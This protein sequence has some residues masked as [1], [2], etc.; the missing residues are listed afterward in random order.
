VFLLFLVC[1]SFAIAQTEPADK[2]D[3]A[4]AAKIDAYIKTYVRGNNFSGN[5]LL[6]RGDRIILRNSYGM[7]NFESSSR[8]APQT[9]FHIASLTKAFTAAAILIL[10]QRGRLNTNDAI[11]KYLPDYPGGEQITIHNL[12]THTSGIPDTYAIPEFKQEFE[13]SRVAGKLEGLAHLIQSHSSAAKPK[14]EFSYSNS[15]YILLAYIIEKL[16]GQT[17]GAFLKENI[18]EPLHLGGTLDDVSDGFNGECA[19]GYEPVDFNGVK[20][21]PYVNWSA[22][23]GAGSMIST[24]SDM[25][26]WV[27]GLYSARVLNRHSTDKMFTAYIHNMGYG[28]F[29]RSRLNRKSVEINGRISGFSSDLVYFPDEDLTIVVLAN[30]VSSLSGSLTDSIAAMTFG[31]NV[32]TVQVISAKAPR[33]ALED[34]PGTYQFG[35]NFRYN[36]DLRAVVQ[37]DGDRLKM[38]VGASTPTYLFP[39]ADGSFVDR[40]FSGVV[41][42]ERDASGKVSRLTWDVGEEFTAQKIPDTSK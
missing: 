22:T 37:R 7:A 1:A 16:S 8:N 11:S 28:W 14:F 15:N 3:R 36:P 9:R 10:E 42:F 17:Y 2:R 39:Q 26:S 29:L 23:T 24:T 40:L 34:F 31:N 12:L 32:Q 13:Q 25:Y 4:L 19:E 6:A 5:V 27:R 35:S 21:A 18:I 38:E 41:K 30:N 20:R 33:H